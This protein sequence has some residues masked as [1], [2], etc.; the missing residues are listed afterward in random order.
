M[1]EVN[2]SFLLCSGS[3]LRAG[4][5]LGVTCDEDIVFQTCCVTSIFCLF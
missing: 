2:N 4:A 3:I 5:S 1:S